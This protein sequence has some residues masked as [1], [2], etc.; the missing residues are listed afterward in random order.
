MSGGS[1][2][3]SAPGAGVL[4][5]PDL[6]LERWPSM[7]RY[8]VELAARIDRLTVP[9][10]WRTMRGP[11]FLSRYRRY[12]RA[13]RRYRPALVHVADHS[14]AHCLRA[15]P[16]VPSVVTLHDL[17][18]LE[19]LARGRGGPRGAV[20]DRLLRW[21]VAWARRADHWIA[22]SCFTAGEAARLLDLPADRVHMIPYGVDEAFSRRPA[23]GELTRRR[24]GWFRGT[25]AAPGA[26]VVL[27]VGSCEPRKGVETA[28]RALGLLR[29]GGVDALLVQI[30]GRF[31]RAQRRVAA[32]AGVASH[33]VQEPSVD[34]AALIV[35]YHAAD[36]LVLP[37]L[38]EGFG[39]PAL[40][41]AA[42]GLPVVSS[43][44][45]GLRQ[46]AGPAAVVAPTGDAAGFAAA[47]A[48]VLTDGALRS[49]LAGAG[50]EHATLHRWETT[51]RL[52]AEVYDRLAS[53]S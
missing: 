45:G 4:L 46:A 6:A 1:A 42:A 39:L 23:E 20:R 26:C 17:Y 28:I 35:A 8:A 40:E 29:A 14:Y 49:T 12:P 21:V 52:T 53:T 41:A 36:V 11:R 18:P 19:V 27:H 13:L 33:V 22:G 50:R 51:A 7:N 48:R 25:G 5:V 16:G 24:E 34:E 38:Y 10:E 37:S 31:S 47:A 15:F 44:V 3:G 43:G 9:V 30:G 2:G 32:E